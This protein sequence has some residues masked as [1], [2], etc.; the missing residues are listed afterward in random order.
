MSDM[1]HHA[2]EPARDTMTGAANRLTPRANDASLATEPVENLR[3]MADALARLGFDVV[4][5][6]ARSGLRRQ[7]L[8]D[9]D[10]RV[11]CVA[12]QQLLGAA[13]AERP[14]P[15]LAAHMASVVPIGAF[16]LLDYLILTT[17]TIAAAL[18]QLERYFSLVT[19]PCKL[20]VVAGEE[21]TRLLVTEASNPFV[22][23]FE[24]SLV[25][26]H[27]REET[28]GALRVSHVSLVDQPE[29]SRDLERLLGCA[30]HA[31]ATWNGIE[32]PR[33]ATRLPLRRRDPGLRRV[34]EGHAASVTQRQSRSAESIVETV[35]GVVVTRLA[36][37]VP[38]LDAVAR[39][40]AMAPRT[41]QRRLAAEGV[42]YQ[43]VVDD[44]RR[45][46]AERLL[47]DPSLAVSQI[48]YLVG[49]SEPSAFHRAF[50]RW[51]FVTPQEY[52]QS[53][54]RSLAR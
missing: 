35:R 6:L 25:V 34:L 43:Q 54:Q 23:Q 16:P 29:D 19:A 2:A 7:D 28:N 36:R 30:V 3:V 4:P 15:N 47:A 13:C 42:S 41:L 8:D 38:D 39:H 51:H 33:A 53:T 22:A 27:L 18:E 37:G 45:D 20:K 50:K 10:G 5:A 26:H 49:F 14:R 52:R 11:P 1:R 31:P 44:V 46:A 40:L 48:G 21:S 12:L 9:P 32:F 17:D 24:T